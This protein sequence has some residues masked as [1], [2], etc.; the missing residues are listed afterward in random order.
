MAFPYYQQNYQPLG[1]YYQQQQHQIPS[2]AGIIWVSGIQ[3]AQMFPVAPNNAV[4]LWENSGKVLYLKTADATG[5]PT[6]RI[7][8][9]VERTEMPSN[10]SAV[11]DDKIP[12]YA[13][14]DEITAILVQNANLTV[15]RIA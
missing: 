4:A 1:V 3:E 11:Q 2:G 15:T 8:D 5:K 7:Y 14:K 6:L 13:T 10:A 12:D 9:L